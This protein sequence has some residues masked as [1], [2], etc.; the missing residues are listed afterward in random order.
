MLFEEKTLNNIMLDMVK[1]VDGDINTDEGTLVNNAF[2]GAAA[3][4]EQVYMNLGMVDQNAYALTADREHL[5][6]RA[7]ERGIVPDKATNAVWK[8]VFNIDVPV[9][10]RFSSRELTYKC[11]EKMGSRVYKVI[12]EQSG[13][14]GNVKR[15]EIE[16]IE[17]IEGY[18]T[19]ELTE[20]LVAARDEEG[21]ESFRTRYLSVISSQSA[22]GGNREQYRQMMHEIEGVGACKIYRV[23]EQERRIKIYFLNSIYKVPSDY[24][25]NEVQRMMDPIGKQG[26]GAG[27]APLFHVVDIY[28]CTQENI[29]IETNIIID[30]GYIWEN[31][32]PEIEAKIDTYFQ[33]LACKWENENCIIVRILRI[34]EAMAD[35]E[36]VIDVQNTRLNGTGGNIMLDANAIPVRGDIICKR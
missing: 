31:M 29:V 33:T 12:C 6:L 19:G 13:T 4:F 2:K 32:L 18:E 34:N 15:G 22:F 17:Y 36:G 25:V 8:A 9:D 26:D 23:T 27:M 11:I 24:L 5:I 3:E 1:S 28:P 16:T 10:S 30:T 7:R 14:T 20:L 35:V 21:T